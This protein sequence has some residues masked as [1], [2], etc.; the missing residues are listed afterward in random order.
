MTEFDRNPYF[1]FLNTAANIGMEMIPKERQY[2]LLACAHAYGDECMVF[3]PRLF[4]DVMFSAKNNG[5]HEAGEPK[6]E[7]ISKIQKYD[8][9]IRSGNQIRE[10]PAF[11]LAIEKDYHVQFG[12][13]I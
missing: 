1:Q 5:I 2:Q 9:E 10:K 13:V 12:E 11:V 3:S 8:Q 4:S 7:V 6:E